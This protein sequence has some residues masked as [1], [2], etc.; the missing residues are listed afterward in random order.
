MR[1]GGCLSIDGDIL[2][3]NYNYDFTDLKDDGTR[4]E[5]GG[6]RYMRP[7]G[8]R[9]V[10]L[11]VKT[12]YGDTEW[13][14]GSGGHIRT[15]SVAREWPVSYHGT[16]DTFAKVIAAEG[17]DLDKGKRFRYGRGDRFSPKK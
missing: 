6:R 11:N 4:F 2:D 3:E 7:Y 10:A 17:Y 1:G 8:W 13:L 15:E 5:R 9:R 16:Q 14:G 12:R